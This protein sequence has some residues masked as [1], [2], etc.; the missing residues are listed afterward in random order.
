MV[1]KS[2][3][4]IFIPWNLNQDHW[5]L[6]I[7]DSNRKIIEYFD[8]KGEKLD[9]SELKAISKCLKVR[10]GSDINFS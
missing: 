10:L 1:P 3:K 4:R 2:N 6:I 7:Y 5:T 9:A 8:S